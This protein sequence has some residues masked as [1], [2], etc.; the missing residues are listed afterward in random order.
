MRHGRLPLNLL[1]LGE[2]ALAGAYRQRLPLV[3]WVY[4]SEHAAQRSRFQA[5]HASFRWSPG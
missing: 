3:Y 1:R 4:A 5:E 2:K